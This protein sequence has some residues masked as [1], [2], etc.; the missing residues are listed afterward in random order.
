MDNNNN[1]FSFYSNVFG[2]IVGSV[3]LITL[4]FGFCM[5][6]PSKKIKYLEA[7]LDETENIFK[8]AL[9]DSLLP[10]QE[11]TSEVEDCLCELREHTRLLRLRVYCVTTWVQDCKELFKGV[12]AEIGKTCYQV[13]LLRAAIVTSSEAERRNQSALRDAATSSASSPSHIVISMDSNTTIDH[14]DGDA[15][16]IPTSELTESA[17]AESSRSNDKAESFTTAENLSDA[18]SNHSAQPMGRVDPDWRR[19]WEYGSR[20]AAKPGSRD[21]FHEAKGEQI[22]DTKTRATSGR[23]LHSACPDPSVGGSSLTNSRS[24]LHA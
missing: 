20:R 8:S 1:S 4:A 5:H 16:S 14:T 9:Q 22:P 6:L 10:Q 23:L 15:P 2:I 3:S 12:S 17:M 19:I 21:R 13:R 24:T 7:L 11:F 18:V